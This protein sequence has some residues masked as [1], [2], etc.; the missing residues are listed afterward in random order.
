MTMPGPLVSLPPWLWLWLAY[1]VWWLPQHLWHRVGEI[2]Q[3]AQRLP[4]RAVMEGHS[5][6]YL[7]LIGEAATMAGTLALTV[8]VILIALPS[9][10]ADRLE[11]RYGLEVAPPPLPA[12]AEIGG[13][14]ASRAPGVELRW[15]PLRLDPLAFVYPIGFRRDGLA[16]SGGLLMLWRKDRPMAEA[17]LCHEL[18]HHDRRE[19]LVIGAG[20]FIEG[21]LR[22]W[23][24]FAL[25]IVVPSAIYFGVG[26]VQSILEAARDEL[27][28]RSWLEIAGRQLQHWATLFGP[29]LI[30]TPIAELLAL[31]GSFALVLAVIWC[32]ELQAD[33]GAL[34][35][36][37]EPDALARL[38]RP[39]RRHGGLA[40]WLLA[41]VSHPPLALR[42]WAAARPAAPSR[43]VLLMAIVPLSLLAHFTLLYARATIVAANARLGSVPGLLESLGSYVASRWLMFV[44]MAAAIVAWSLSHALRGRDLRQVAPAL[45]VAAALAALGSAPL[46]SQ[47]PSSSSAQ[48]SQSVERPAFVMLSK[49]NYGS[50]EPIVV[51]FAGL[52]GMDS[53]GLRIVPWQAP[54]G[55]DGLWVST[56]GASYGSLTLPPLAPGDYEVRIVRRSGE[57][58]IERAK[59]I[60]VVAAD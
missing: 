20:S 44:A 47:A 38:Y 24:L 19:A 34:M 13:F 18:A 52:S 12:V 40:R 60:F 39:Q 32:A 50:R 49:L 17:V 26:S 55:A 21:T 36:G 1:F 43:I 33:R 37:A 7:L 51:T 41:R 59:M 3:D 8:G 4:E 5:A 15:T 46:W 54:A 45:A 2:V 23:W 6:A 29:A 25:L 57:E 31:I 48:A 10:R 28:E 11:R 42:R 22:S 35:R 9:M 30:T 14:V 53:E 27:I 16:A 58:D 56:A